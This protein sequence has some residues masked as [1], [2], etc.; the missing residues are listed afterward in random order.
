[1]D[2]GQYWTWLHVIKQEFHLNWHVGARNVAYQHP[3]V[4]TDAEGQVKSWNDKQSPEPLQQ[5]EHKANLEDVGVEHH[6]QNDDH[7]E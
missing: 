3:A 4:E 6:Q 2:D 1:M 7:A 5:Q